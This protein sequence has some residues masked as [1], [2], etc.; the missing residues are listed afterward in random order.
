ML[1]EALA[2]NTA[3]LEGISRI[4]KFDHQFLGYSV[5][6]WAMGL[7][8]RILV[9]LGRFADAVRCLDQ[10][11]NIEQDLVDP[12]VLL[13]P[14]LGYVDLAWCR[15]D[16]VLAD[17]HATRVA[18]I[19]EKHG[20]PYLR[21]FALACGGTAKTIAKDFVRALHE[22]TEGLEFLRKTKAAMEYEPE[23]LASLADCY[24][25]SRELERA[26]A[27]AREGIEIAQRR[28]ARLPECRASITCGAA[29]IAAHGIAR[30]D[31]AE[32]LFRR[33]EDLI[34]Q[35]GATIYERL[36]TKERARLSVLVC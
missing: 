20:N 26:I 23:I 6:R 28:S 30:A 33:A 4:E 36:L 34:R 9:R 32:A 8:G 21:V 16:A 25:R 12:T 24:Y 3:A 18:E 5:E 15:G 14:H 7:R 13:I 29:L 22:F 19:A 35:S 31:E 10:V 1:N 27:T 17:R 2:A 11:L